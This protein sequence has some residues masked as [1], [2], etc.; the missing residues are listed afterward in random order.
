MYSKL[1]IL[2]IAVI[3]LMICIVP[4]QSYALCDIGG[5]G[6]RVIHAESLPFNNAAAGAMSFWI[7]PA[8]I[9]PTFYYVFTT[10]NQMFINF[11]NTA[12]A[13]NQQVRVTGTAAACGAAG[14]L[15]AGGTIVAV[16]RDSFQ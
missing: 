13:T 11:L 15:R 10:S 3:G 16:F 8:T 5:A 14:T 2:A 1:I 9:T 6:G 4:S 12:H 7:A